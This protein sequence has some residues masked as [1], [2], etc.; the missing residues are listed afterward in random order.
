MSL[1]AIG[2]KKQKLDVKYPGVRGAMDGN[3]DVTSITA[4]S[5]TDSDLFDAV[6]P[7]QHGADER[8][9][10]RCCFHTK[11]GSGS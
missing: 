11:L 9:F 5:R 8:L 6:T 1:F 2:R 4:I 3:T 10:G 7:I